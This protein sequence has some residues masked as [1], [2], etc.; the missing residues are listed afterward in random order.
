MSNL[1]RSAALAVMMAA[2]VGLRAQTASWP[3]WGGPNRD[4][5]APA[6]G[7][8]PAWPDGGP[9]P[10][11]SRELGEGYSSIVVDGGTLYTQYRPVKGLVATVLSKLQSAGAET[12]VVIAVDA[13]T[14]RTLWEH[15]YDAPFAPRMNLE[16]GPGPHATPLVVGDLVYTVGVTGKLFAFEKRAGRV[17]WSHDLWGEYKGQVQGRGYASSPLAYKD[18]V[19]VPVG[20]RGQALMAFDQKTGTLRWKNGDLDLAPSSPLL[21]NVDGQDQIVL[22]HADGVAGLEA[23]GG[24]LL[25]N[26][27]H[28]TD[29]G[30]NISTPVWGSDNLLFI[31]SAYSGG[32]RVLHLAQAGGR[33]AVR[34]LWFSPKMRLHIANAVRLG[35]KVYGSSGDF[36]PAFFTAVDVRTGQ[37]AWQDRSFSRAHAVHADGRLI[38]VDEDGTVA[39]ASVG[40]GGLTVHSRAELLASKAWTAPTVVGTRLYLRDRASMKA[41]D[42]G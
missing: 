8:K 6:A 16:Y 27:P 40:P 26:H 3:Q 5:K 24:A 35:D 12:E 14:G 18:D 29:Y 22:F 4:F 17:A 39:L 30:L 33:T 25:W 42:L 37:I 31:S 2:A 11:W 19:I 23:S 21:I 28:K 38:I 15:R 10:L 20:G 13:A 1:R 32:S 34:E 7:L 36:G 9:R 41:F